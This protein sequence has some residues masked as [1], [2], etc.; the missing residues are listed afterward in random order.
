MSYILARVH[1]MGKRSHGDYLSARPHR[2]LADLELDFRL[3]Q[4]LG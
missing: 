3:R 4:M 2:S 1:S